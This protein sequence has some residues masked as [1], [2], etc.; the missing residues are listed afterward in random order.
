MC[1]PLLFFCKVWACVTLAMNISQQLLNPSVQNIRPW[2]GNPF[3]GDTWLLASPKVPP[4]WRR[5][6]QVNGF[7][8]SVSFSL[9]FASCLSAS[10]FIMVS[11]SFWRKDDGIYSV[12]LYTVSS[13]LLP[14]WRVRQLLI[15]HSTVLSVVRHDTVISTLIWHDVS[16]LCVFLA[17]ALLTLEPVRNCT[18][19]SVT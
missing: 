5:S 9:S 14:C 15:H 3:I 2:G 10:E 11:L 4:P 6:C 1:E 13:R 12:Y 19:L 18:V 16:Y 7:Q 17:V 8:V